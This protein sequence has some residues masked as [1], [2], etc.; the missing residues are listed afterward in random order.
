M[1]RP[2]PLP[3]GAPLGPDFC[4]VRRLRG[5]AHRWLYEVTDAR[6]ER[7]TRTCW[8]CRFPGAPREDGFCPRCGNALTDRL[9]L[10]S[11]RWDPAS[12]DAWRELAASHRHPGLLSPVVVFEEDKAL[13]SVTEHTQARLLLDVPA[14]LPTPLLIGAA[15]TLHDTLRF[16][17]S[18]GV[19]LSRLDAAHVLVADDGSVC[20]FDLD[21]TAE[22]EGLP[23]TALLALLGSYLGPVGQRLPDGQVAPPELADLH[24]AA[25]TD[26]GLAR[27]HNED[28]WTWTAPEPGVALYA[29]ADGLGGLQAGETASQLALQ[30]L[31]TTVCRRL[32]EGALPGDAVLLSAFDA[33]ERAVADYQ[34][35]HQ[36][37]K[38]A[39]TLVVA[40][41]VDDK[42]Y[43]AHIGDSRAYLLRRGT[44]ERLTED[45]SLVQSLVRKG[46]IP[47]ALAHK[48]ALSNVLERAVGVGPA[49]EP[50]LQTLALE[51]GDRLLLCSDG[52]WGE[53][54]D[55]VL[56]LV[57]AQ[58][59]SPTLACQ[60]L[61]RT[62]HAS[63]AHDNLTAIVLD[64]PGEP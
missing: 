51:A 63:G 44:L 6:P 52:V 22:G 39:T 5:T 43:L 62:V 3:P 61:V 32:K 20:W 40:L 49:A 47:A 2:P 59:P 56:Q 46:H 13:V 7:R 25:I 11:V 9:F 23:P 10:A 29:V 33:A 50:D 38:M 45:H 31:R 14:P 64:I 53:L 1:T 42:A 19:W 16:L 28:G 26:V 24:A 41:V 12:F 35:A 54:G 21:V 27:A 48:H 36:L 34:R 17:S 37:Q 55:E 8:S 60:A 15:R 57:L 30:A 4:V 18:R 58:S